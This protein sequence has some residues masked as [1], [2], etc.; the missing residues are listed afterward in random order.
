MDEG[1]SNNVVSKRLVDKLSLKTIPHTRPYKLNWISKEGETNVNK[2][3]LINFS[4][5]SYKDEAL[6]DVVPMEVTYI[7]LGRPCQFHKQT[8]HDGYTDKYI[9]FTH[10]KKNYFTTSITS[11]C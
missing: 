1:S 11:R 2:Q 9:F 3:V 10:G 6:C 8:L 4:I 7:L 5:G